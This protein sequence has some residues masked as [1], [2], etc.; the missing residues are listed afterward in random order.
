MAPLN[1]LTSTLTSLNLTS[2]RGTAV[3]SVTGLAITAAVA[4]VAQAA[5]TASTDPALL[6]PA[7][8]VTNLPTTVSVP[9]IS[10]SADV[11]DVED[12]AATAEAPAPEPVAAEETTTQAGTA[13]ATAATAT[14]A[15]TAS[16]A[17]P[18]NVS[19]SSIVGIAYSLLGIPYA[20][21]GSSLAGMDCS[22]FTQ[23]VYAQAGISIPR[24]SYAQEAGGTII[25]ASEAVPGDLLSW[26][27]HVAIYIGDGMMIDSSTPGTVTSVR[28]I[29]GSPVYVRY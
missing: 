22:G 28:A 17:I 23:Y 12:I 6:S 9:D 13:T 24:T 7:A 5:P 3:V 27:Y 20:Y 11:E 15:A 25:P 19:S 10:W 4:G 1:D 2:T 8:N 18:A 26:G 21:G 29:W 14:T 16:A